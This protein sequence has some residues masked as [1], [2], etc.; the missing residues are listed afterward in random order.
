MNFVH[1]NIELCSYKLGENEN[2]ELFLEKFNAVGEVLA[3]DIPGFISRE[4]YKNCNTNLFAEI[5]TWQNA[6]LAEAGEHLITATPEFQHFVACIDMSSFAVR[7]AEI[8][9]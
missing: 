9:E 5:I 6:T 3:K 7:H 2:E 1:T 8:V 4:I